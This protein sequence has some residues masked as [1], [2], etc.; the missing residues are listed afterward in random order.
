[1]ES[2]I[3]LEFPEA[4][5]DI[6]RSHTLPQ[7]VAYRLS[8]AH[9]NYWQH[10]AF[11]VLEQYYQTKDIF[12]YLGEV[13]TEIDLAVKLHCAAANLYWVYQLEDEYLLLIQ[14]KRKGAEL[15]TREK[16]HRV[17]Y[18][19]AGDHTAYFEK[20][21]HYLIFYFVVDKK[22]L[23]RFQDSSLRF[24]KRLLEKLDCEHPEFAFTVR[25]PI[26]AK[27]MQFIHRLFDLSRSDELAMEERIPPIILRLIALARQHDS[28]E[29]Q[30]IGKT[31]DKLNQIRRQV[32]E[33]IQEGRL[34]TIHELA[35]DFNFNVNY[36][37]QSHKKHYQESLQRFI[38]KSKLAEAYRQIAD[39]HRAPT[40][41][42]HALG[43]YDG[44]AFTNA[45]KKEY[46]IVPS[47]LFQKKW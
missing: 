10:S 2:L 27:T 3:Q 8:Y 4:L 41:V 14:H 18:L 20:G 42:A 7:S 31:V 33:N 12:L 36:L 24:L 45:F 5:G 6:E 34:F 43:F 21:G 25:L 1:M 32:L 19:P 26:D 37:R 28:K 23:L 16:T 39:E 13:K 47:D 44:A 11:T 35:E 17:V 15:K 9:C 38:T 29:N 22:L 30:S 40:E 46:G